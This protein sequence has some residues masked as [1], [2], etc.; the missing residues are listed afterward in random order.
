M[1]FFI[2]LAT[3]KKKEKSISTNENTTAH[4]NNLKIVRTFS[5]INLIPFHIKTLEKAYEKKDWNLA[6]LSYAKIIEIVRQKNIN[7]KG[8]L[9]NNLKT[10][11][12][13]YEQFR[14]A[15]DLEYLAQFLPPSE[16]K[17]KTSH[18]SAL[19]YLEMFYYDEF[20]K[21]LIEHIDVVRTVDQ[22]IQ[23]GF[24]PKQD[25]FGEWNYVQRGGQDFYFK[26]IKNPSPREKLSLET[27]KKITQNPYHISFLMEKGCAIDDFV[28]NL[29]DLPL[30]FSA[31]EEIDKKNYSQALELLQKAIQNRPIEEYKKLKEYVEIKLGNIDIAERK[32]QEYEFDIDSA[33]HGGEIYNWLHALLQNKKY[34]RAKYFIQKTNETLDNLAKGK[35]KAK[36]YGQQKSEWYS[37]K[38]EDFHKHLDKI[39]DNDLL[40]LE[41]S[42]GTINLLEFYLSLYTG[43]DIKTIE[44]IATLYSSWDLK[45]KSIQLYNKCLDKLANEEKPKVKAR[46]NKK[47]ADL[48]A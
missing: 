7:E 10:L 2:F 38:K 3:R 14:Q 46:I 27:G 18:S 15:H 41:K 45:E 34:D 47:L 6:N 4:I 17:K 22:W 35:I 23:L 20:P 37:Y 21:L 31:Q 30:F 16:R 48:T 43:K 19:L 25:E 33:V 32:F 39:F 29:D 26:E 1:G 24:K 28:D 9:E 8:K 42:D 11:R 44:Q 13:E 40:Q 12:E 36:I 5:G